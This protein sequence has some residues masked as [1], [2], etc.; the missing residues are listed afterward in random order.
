[1]AKSATCLPGG[2]NSRPFAVPAGAGL[3]PPALA[4]FTASGT[5]LDP[6]VAD[7]AANVGWPPSGAAAFAVPRD[8]FGLASGNLTTAWRFCAAP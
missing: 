4:A 2:G 8:L 6:G 3:G 5:L 1:V 7:F